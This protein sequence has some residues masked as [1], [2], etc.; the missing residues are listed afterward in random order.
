MIAVVSDEGRA[1][2]PDFLVSLIGGTTASGVSL[3]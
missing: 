1:S 3:S 2:M